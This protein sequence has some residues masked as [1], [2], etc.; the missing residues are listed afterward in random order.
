MREENPGLAATEYI[1][2]KHGKREN[3]WLIPLDK[4]VNERAR[5]LHEENRKTL[6]E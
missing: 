4:D 2:Y 3:E 6:L 1:N 5:K